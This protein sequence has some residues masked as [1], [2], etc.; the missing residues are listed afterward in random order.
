MSGYTT[1]ALAVTAV[2]SA[3]A[4]YESGQQQKAMG[5]YQ[6]DQAQAD[7]D[8]EQSAA[9]V[10]AAKIRKLAASQAGQANASLAASGVEVGEGTALEINEGIYRDAEEDA[11]MTIIN[12]NNSA[13]KTTQQ[14]VA[15]SI[16]GNQA[17]TAGTV[18]AA[19]S[20][21]GGAYSGYS[22]WKKSTATK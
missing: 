9:Q 14:G 17:A 3:G 13:A 20:L 21:I 22:N 6:A 7:A 10:Q 12:G 18:S 2:I 4:A 5:E 16:Q 15:A 19:T 8:A 1:A 11:A